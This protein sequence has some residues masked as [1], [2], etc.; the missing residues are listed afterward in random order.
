MKNAIKI[1]SQEARDAFIKAISTE[2]FAK[3]I[4]TI[5][6]ATE[7]GTF[8]VVVSTDNIDRSG[9]SVKQDGWNL[10]HYKKNPI[11]LWAHDYAS[12]P[13]GMCTKIEVVGNQLIAEG[14]FAPE[15]ANP[16][17]QQ[18][19]K[20]YDAGMITA[21]SVGFIPTEMDGN[22]ITKAELLEFSFVPV[23][24]NPYAL[25]LNQ[26]SD[27]K[28]NVAMLATKGIEIKEEPE[29]VEPPV[30]TPAPVATE[31]TPEP[32][33]EEPAPVA[34][35]GKGALADEMTSEQTMEAKYE[36]LNGLWDKFDAFCNVYMDEATPV[37]A[38]D[39]LIKE[40]VALLQGGTPAEAE[41]GAIAKATEN[42][43][44]KQS[45]QNAAFKIAIAT[46]NKA[47]AA[48]EG[49]KG[50]STGSDGEQQGGTPA[51]EKKVVASGV[52]AN[53]EEAKDFLVAR[54]TLK[55]V[56]EMIGG[57]LE[58]MNKRAREYRKK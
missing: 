29:A 34:E 39:G 45:G 54:D 40:L 53:K 56:A 26:I 18:V 46:A 17:A 37:E 7:A 44:R 13:I 9:E 57:S 50:A 6:A 19:R 14:M 21:T 22:D 33:V 5:K 32:K 10:E 55:E 11:V 16:F 24:A 12:L 38:F 31:P 1:F 30:E 3:S 42:K 27:M 15:E 20:L 48:I 51:P 2:A 49:L 25:R 36:K 28:L 52:P 35:E 4:E 58:R 23:P 47:I 43:E 41:K 8:K